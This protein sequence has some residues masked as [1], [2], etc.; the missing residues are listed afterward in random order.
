MISN[1]LEFRIDCDPPR[2][3]HHAKKIV[4]MGRFSRLADTPDLVAARETWIALLRPF[5]PANPIPGPICLQLEFTWPWRGSD[6]KRDRALGSIPSVVKPDCSNAAKTVEDIMALLRFFENDNEVS[7][8][9]AS[10]Y[11]GDRPGLKV[12]V[13]TIDFR[14]VPGQWLTG[15]TA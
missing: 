15:V 2:T 5:A 3:T 13:G 1:L 10:K 12:S 4:R 8:L 9:R 11:L 14:P 7:D 6:T